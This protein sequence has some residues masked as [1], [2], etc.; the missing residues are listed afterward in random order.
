VLV[1]DALH[2]KDPVDGQGIYDALLAAKLLAEELR[3]W[4]A[5]EQRWGEL[6]VRYDQR[7]RE[8]TYGMF[9]AT[10]ARLQRELYQEPPPVVMKTLMRWM[11]EDPEYQRRFL[12]FLCRSMPPDR[13]LTPGVMGRAVA[14]GVLGDLRR[15]WPARSRPRDARP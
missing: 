4:L 9:M 6:L 5:G 12:S 8:G 15:L 11:L 14:R 10:M 2:H 1:G 13:W 3:A 7:V